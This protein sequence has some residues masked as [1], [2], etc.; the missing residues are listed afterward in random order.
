MMR[1]RFFIIQD[2]VILTEKINE[3]FMQIKRTLSYMDT[4]PH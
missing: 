2:E 1:I 4:T 3:K